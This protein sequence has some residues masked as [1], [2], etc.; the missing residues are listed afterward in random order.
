MNDTQQAERDVEASRDRVE[1]T[2]DALRGKMDT[3]AIIEEVGRYLNTSGA[4]EMVANLGRQVRENPLPLVLVGA[5]LAWLA[6][7]NGPRLEPRARLEDQKWD[8]EDDFGRTEPAGRGLAGKAANGLKQAGSAIGKFAGD[9][10]DEAKSL[11]SGATSTASDLIAGAEHGV[12]GMVGSSRVASHRVAGTAKHAASSLQDYTRR[13]EHGLARFVQEEPLAVGA[14]GLALGAAVGAMLPSTP[15]EDRLMGETRDNLLAEA[16][17]LAGDGLAT[18]K[19]RAE[20]V[21]EVAEEEVA[22]GY[23]KVKEGA[24]RAFEDAKS[25]LAATSA[26]SG[27]RKSSMYTP[28]RSRDA[29]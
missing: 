20:S 13:A 23:Q 1:R 8:A 29:D 24:S 14:I 17:R 28:S 22:T 5:G 21:L 19:D 27:A 16:E 4:S 10:V 25:A 9:V 26:A 12:E 7:G 6:L 18:V 2:V 11:A 15:V 3:G